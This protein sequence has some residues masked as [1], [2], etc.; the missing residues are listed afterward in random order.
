MEAQL[1]AFQSPQIHNSHR[2]GLREHRND[3]QTRLLSVRSSMDI[4][5]K[6]IRISSKKNMRTFTQDERISLVIRKTGKRIGTGRCNVAPSQTIPQGDKWLID[7][8]ISHDVI[9]VL[10]GSSNNATIGQREIIRIRDS[11]TV[12][13][14]RTLREHTTMHRLLGQH[15]VGRIEFAGHQI[16]RNRLWPVGQDFVNRLHGSQRGHRFRL[17]HLIRALANLNAGSDRISSHD[18]SYD[19]CRFPVFV[20]GIAEILNVAEEPL[21]EEL[22]WEGHVILRGLWESI[23]RKFYI[24]ENMG[25]TLKNIYIFTTLIRSFNLGFKEIKLCYT[26]FSFKVNRIYIEDI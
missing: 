11:L 2:F 25:F 17:T 12:L 8:W 24:Y 10:S 19:A 26:T 1:F 20:L 5:R 23:S 6:C 15:S 3:H 9:D 4:R 22:Q 18:D 13:A 7:L 14:G 21:L 16:D